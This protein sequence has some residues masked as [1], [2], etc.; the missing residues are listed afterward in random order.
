MAKPKV[1]ID[2]YLLNWGDKLFYP[3]VRKFKQ[4][5][6]KSLPWTTI[7]L[8]NKSGEIRAQIAR[9][10]Q[11]SPE[12]MVK[13]TSRNNAGKSMM[14][15]RNHLDYISRNGKVQLEDHEGRLLHGRADVN[16]IKK[17]WAA[18]IPEIS[19]RR[20]TINVMFSMRKGTPSYEVKEAVRE[21]LKE[22]FGGKHEYLFAL[23]TD[24]DNPHVHVVIK[25]S[26]VRKKDKRLNPR[27]NDLQ[28]WREGFAEN[29]RKLGVDANATPRKTR[30]VVKQPLQQYQLHQLARNTEATQVAT[31][32]KSSMLQPSKL[33]IGE[34]KKRLSNHAQQTQAWANIASA[35]AS[36]Q[37]KSDR[38]LA[39]DVI[40]F[41]AEQP[42]RHINKPNLNKNAQ[43]AL[44]ADKSVEGDILPLPRAK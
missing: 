15:I 42:I 7:I 19:H 10:T 14:T 30:G 29:L 38:V 9:T 37:T 28:R 36:S 41:M 16:D 11:R 13:V 35:L 39:K 23:H 4:R 24:T 12:V 40:A 18:D 20:E 8:P 17:D 34:A 26:P 25:M 22:E 33:Q 31:P 44:K 3:P 2:G 43:R 27:K 6:V 5:V 1:F 32:L 21:Y